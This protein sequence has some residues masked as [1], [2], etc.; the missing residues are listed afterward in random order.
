LKYNLLEKNSEIKPH[1]T[2]KQKICNQ[3][4]SA[5]GHINDSENFKNSGDTQRWRMAPTER[6][7]TKSEPQ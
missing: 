6:D 2:F 7:T 5:G 1:K 4:V 3:I